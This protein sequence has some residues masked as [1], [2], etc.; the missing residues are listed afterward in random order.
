MVDDEM[1]KEM[2]RKTEQLL[3]LAKQPDPSLSRL[4]LI[5]KPPEKP[6]PKDT[7]EDQ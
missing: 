7:E 4:D 5:A 3:E 6:E 2:R 1:D